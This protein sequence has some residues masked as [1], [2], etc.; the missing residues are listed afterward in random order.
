MWTIRALKRAGFQVNQNKNS[1]P[2]S[3][4][5]I[6]KSKQVLWKITNSQSVY[7]HHSLYEM[8][9]FLDCS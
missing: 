3:V 9:K 7:T 8:I 6:T 5:V 1:L 2:I 4:E